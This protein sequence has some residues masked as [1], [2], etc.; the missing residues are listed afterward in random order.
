MLSKFLLNVKPVS[1]PVSL[2]QFFFSSF[3]F[4]HY[5]FQSHTTFS[6][7]ILINIRSYMCVAMRFGS[8]VT[9]SGQFAAYC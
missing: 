1:T 8:G 7:Y 4:Y 2:E 9:R 6:E 5:T 3:R